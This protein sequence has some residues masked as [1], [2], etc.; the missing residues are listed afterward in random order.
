MAEVR[1]VPN[2]TDA[3]TQEIERLGPWFHNLHLPG[4]TAAPARDYTLEERSALSEPSWPRMAFVEDRLHGDPT[5]W[6]VPNV[7]CLEA[8]I[9][10][11][12]LLPGRIAH[13]TFLC[14]PAQ[15]R[16]TELDELNEAQYRAAAGLNT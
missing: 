8:L 13:D 5:N 11:A 10:S 1:G 2:E 12:G 4:E 6:W 7:P 15:S 9:R 3:V 14:K 16:R